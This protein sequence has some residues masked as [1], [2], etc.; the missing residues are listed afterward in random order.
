MRLFSRIKAISVQHVRIPLYIIRIEYYTRN[1]EDTVSDGLLILLLPFRC[2]NVNE[3]RSLERKENLKCRAKIWTA[4]VEYDDGLI[5]KNAWYYASATE[6]LLQDVVYI[7]SSFREKNAL[8]LFYLQ[9][10]LVQYWYDTLMLKTAMRS[11]IKH[12]LF[13]PVWL[14]LCC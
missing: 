3:K 4:A 12:F 13:S 7:L 6:F 8:H 1:Y 9:N 11:I 10:N 2:F 14:K 5:N